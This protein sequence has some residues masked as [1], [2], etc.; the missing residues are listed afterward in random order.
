MLAYVL[1]IYG[2]VLTCNGAQLQGKVEPNSVWP[3]NLI[4]GILGVIVA[5]QIG[6]TGSMGD[7]SPLI[8]AL[9]CIFAITFLMF[10][11]ILT[12]GL[13]V[14]ALGYHCIFGTVFSL[15]CSYAFFIKMGSQTFGWA[16]I[17]WAGLFALF[18]GLLA[19]GK[20]WGTVTGIYCWF[21]VVFTLLIPASMMLLGVP[22][23]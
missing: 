19:F 11:A 5:L 13:D 23:P 9:L 16:T 2:T 3:I 4:G 7:L 21:L 14:K 15:I 10:A 20:P 17:V 6:I 1:I 18:A 22:L 8:A 12:S